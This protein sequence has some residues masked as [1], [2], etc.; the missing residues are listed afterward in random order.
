MTAHDT[1][2]LRRDLQH[3]GVSA[4]DILIVHSSMKALGKV[5]GGPNAVV[6]ALRQCVGESGTI[7]MP[8]FSDPQIDDV[9]DL[10]STPSRTGIVTETFRTTHGVLRSFHPTHS[11]AA[12]GAR[13]AEFVTGHD[14]TSGLGV[15]SPLHKAALSGAMVLMLGCD[16]DAASIVHVA[17]AI[18]RVPYFGRVWYAGYDRTLTMV[19]PDGKRVLVPPLDPPTCSDAFGVVQ[20]DMTSHDLVRTV[21]IGDAPSQMFSARDAIH[22]ALSLLDGNVHALL[23]HNPRCPV[24]VKARAL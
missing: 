12:I 16:M 19:L 1:D 13:A 24:C 18:S 11:I 14:K 10:R 4:G 9:F 8:V 20:R 5:E 3:A 22:S 15:G 21:N 6:A 23:C 2:S 17:E 7:L